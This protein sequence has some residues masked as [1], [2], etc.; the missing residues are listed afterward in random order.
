MIIALIGMSI[1]TAWVAISGK[2]YGAATIRQRTGGGPDS[3][4]SGLA[5]PFV[6]EQI[7]SGD[8]SVNPFG[9]V[10]F[11]LDHS[12]YGHSGIDIPLGH[13]AVIV[14]VAK[15]EILKIDPANDGRPGYNVTLRI[16]TPYR[17]GEAWVF[18]YEHII[19]DPHFTVGSKVKRGQ[20]LGLT[21][22]ETSYN[23]HFQLSYAFNNFSYTRNH[24]C[25]IDRLTP[26][27]ATELRSWFTQ[28]S[29]KET[30]QQVWRT[31]VREG[32]YEFRKLLD[33]S[34]FPH[35]PQLCYPPG[36]DAR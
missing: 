12:E 22:L 25:W 5:L 27:T 28:L 20:R 21:A 18:L 29:A 17:S 26:K 10:R 2:M 24:T 23:N 19:P 34:L 16:A 30:F 4:P 13:G 35:G 7:R 31:S 36:T 1:V 15:G 9:V 6:M 11:S 8:T 3:P 32:K 14:A 33:S